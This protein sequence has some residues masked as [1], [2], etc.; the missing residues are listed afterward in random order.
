MNRFDC[1]VYIVLLHVCHVLLGFFIF[2]MI[3]ITINNAICNSMH[4]Y[5]NKVFYIFD[6]LLFV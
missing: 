5:F 4:I 6:S 3:L 2:K 1:I